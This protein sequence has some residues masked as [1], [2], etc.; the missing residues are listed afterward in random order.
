MVFASG[1]TVWV[2][3]SVW[4]ASAASASA[5]ICGIDRRSSA[6]GPR[7]PSAGSR[8]RSTSLTSAS[9]AAFTGA[10]LSGSR[11]ACRC[12]MPRPSSRIVSERSMRSRSSR[13]STPSGSSRASASRTPRM[14]VSSGTCAASSTSAASTTSTL[15][16]SAR[17]DARSSIEVIADAA[18]MPIFAASKAAAT[19]GCREGRRSPLKVWRC[20]VTVP[21]VISLSA[22]ARD[23]RVDAAISRAGLWN[24][25]AFANPISPN[26]GPDRFVTSAATL[27]STA[28]TSRRT[29]ASASVTC[30]SPGSLICSTS[31]CAA[32]PTAPH[33]GI[34]PAHA[35]RS[36]AMSRSSAASA[37][38]GGCG[39]VGCSMFRSCTH[40]LTSD[41]AEKS[42]VI[43]NY[44]A[45]K[46]AQRPAVEEKSPG[47]GVRLDT[48]GRR[49]P[50]PVKDRGCAGRI[51]HSTAPVSALITPARA[52]R[53]PP[54]TGRAAAGSPTPRSVHHPTPVRRR[55]AGFRR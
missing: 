29:C 17:A 15:L 6:T 44:P 52:G 9:I 47:R 1:V 49:H 11:R 19:C 4:R 2:Q 40:P 16:A 46:F 38:S 7:S 22:S 41:R 45:K 32:P 21:T 3:P 25:C 33:A 18:S 36:A 8:R 53:T 39:G 35:S 26:S 50:P 10:A 37:C 34:E 42:S 27:A 51:G 54:R 28:S 24:P 5:W 20:A 12:T 48:P 55:E 14:S 13:G 30:R 31:T 43:R 23:A